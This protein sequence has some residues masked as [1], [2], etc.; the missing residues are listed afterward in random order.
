MEYLAAYT[1]S[2]VVQDIE[3]WIFGLACIVSW[4]F[5]FIVTL[6]E[7]GIVSFIYSKCL[8][9]HPK[10]VASVHVTVLCR[11]IADVGEEW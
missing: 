7:T 6:E 1:A 5:W 11:N 9:I 8:V 10:A 3:M 2:I 4:M